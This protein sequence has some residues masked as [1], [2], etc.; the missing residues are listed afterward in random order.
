MPLHTP[1]VHNPAPAVEEH[2]L[3]YGHP[4]TENEART[5]DSLVCARAVT[6]SIDDNIMLN[7]QKLLVF[8]G[9]VLLAITLVTVFFAPPSGST[10]ATAGIVA[11]CAGVVCV[12]AAFYVSAMR[13]F[14]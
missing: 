8:L 7:L 13:G 2:E 3:A 5:E 12:L 10:F 1:E 6:I 9:G 11:A 14:R 4:R